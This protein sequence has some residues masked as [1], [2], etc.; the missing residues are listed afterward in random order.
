MIAM[1]ISLVVMEMR[2]VTLLYLWW[3]QGRGHEVGY[4]DD[5]F[6]CKCDEVGGSGDEFS[7]TI[8]PVVVIRLVA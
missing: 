1:V 7:Y 2:L 4:R 8:V 6:G 5:E 3:S